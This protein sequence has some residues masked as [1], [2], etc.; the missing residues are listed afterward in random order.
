M[1]TRL[2]PAAAVPGPPCRRLAFI[3][4]YHCVAALTEDCQMNGKNLEILSL[5]TIVVLVL[6]WA[7]MVL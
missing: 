5:I 6:A 7:A 4:Q 2:Y 1:E 3:L